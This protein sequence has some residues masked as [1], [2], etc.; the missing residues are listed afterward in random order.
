[1]MMMMMMTRMQV[2]KVSILP[3]SRRLPS[4]D[5]VLWACLTHASVRQREEWLQGMLLG[6]L[7]FCHS[8][9]INVLLLLG[10]HNQKPARASTWVRA[11]QS[12][13]R[14]E[15]RWE[16]QA[17]K[18]MKVEQCLHP[19]ASQAIH[20]ACPHHEFLVGV[21]GVVYDRGNPSVSS[22]TVWKSLV[23]VWSGCFKHWSNLSWQSR[24]Q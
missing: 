11:D 20:L 1:M 22:F 17:Q 24:W 7:V 2:L 14:G 15:W 6:D 4:T 16:E 12:L 9:E 21:T 18:D 19:R 8:W 23:P 3:R 10:N 5:C 13:H